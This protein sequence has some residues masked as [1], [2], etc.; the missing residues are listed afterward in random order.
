MLV[1]GEPSPVCAD[2]DDALT[3]ATG[4]VRST[5]RTWSPWSGPA[6]GSTRG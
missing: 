3:L 1:D 2:E 5:A 6:R 4:G